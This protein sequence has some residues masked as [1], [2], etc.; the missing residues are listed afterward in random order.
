MTAGSESEARQVASHSVVGSTGDAKPDA[1]L[2]LEARGISKSFWGRG[3]WLMRGKENRALDEVSITLRQG[4]ILGL[5]GESGCGKSTL[6]KVLLGLEQA[7]AG[8]LTLDGRQIFAPG[9]RPVPAAR[10]GIQMVF[11]DPFGSLNPRMAVRDLVGEGLRIEGKLSK[12]Q[13]TDEVR[14]HLALVGLGDDALTKYAHQFSGGQRQRLCVARA[15]VLQPRLLIADEAVSALDVSVQM[16][17]LNLLLD[18]RERLGLSL[19]FIS[20]D[21]GVIEYLCDRISVMYG[22]RI[23]EEG[24]TARLL[25]EPRHPYTAHL[26]ASRPRI[27][28]SSR[29]GTS[30][31][32]DE[33]AAYVPVAPGT[34]CVY[35][36]RCPHADA[37]CKSIPPELDRDGPTAIACHHPLT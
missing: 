17:I 29:A 18:L 20:H 11:Q 24:M 30:L 14:R 13:I 22:G 25:A 3:A 12:S 1:A 7:D 21:M 9:A 8:S 16:Q 31:G 27:G 23:V 19:I 5:V 26:I 2:L 34:A 6:A 35:S 37:T 10:R 36:R 28:G 33:P 15:I 32:V 4:E